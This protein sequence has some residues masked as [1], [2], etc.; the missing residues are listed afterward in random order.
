MWIQRDP[1]LSTATVGLWLSFAITILL[2]A[3]I[4]TR[5]LLAVSVVVFIISAALSANFSSRL[6]ELLVLPRVGGSSG[7]LWSGR[8]WVLFSLGC[9]LYAGQ[10]TAMLV[11]LAVVLKGSK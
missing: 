11:L 4:E 3:A 7:R 5:K 6:M 9:L 10:I 1:V 8:H 2:A